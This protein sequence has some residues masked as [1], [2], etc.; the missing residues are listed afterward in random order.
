MEEEIDKPNKKKGKTKLKSKHNYGNYYFCLFI[1]I[2]IIEIILIINSSKKYE[3]EKKI[4]KYKHD[5]I[6]NKKN[7]I[8]QLIDEIEKNEKEIKYLESKKIPD[9]NNKLKL[10]QNEQFILLNNNKNLSEIFSKSYEEYETRKKIF[11]EEIIE[12]NNTLKK[13]YNELNNKVIIRTNLEEKLDII[14]SQLTGEIPNIKI[15]SSILENDENKIL[16]L[17]KWISSTT[18]GEIKKYKLIFSAIEHDFDS[19]SF[20]EI[21]GNEDI[22]N[23]LIIIKTENNDIIG[24]FTFASWR[25]NSLISYDDKAFVFNLNKEIKLRV[26]NP[27]YAINS[28]INDGPIFGIYDLIINLNKLKIQEKMESYGDKDLE[29]GNNV[30]KIDNYEVFTIIFK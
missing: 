24:G 20:H 25:A 10:I 17:T 6:V 18:G 26:S 28:K 30:I 23:T 22:D 11:E 19:F 16:L 7:N 3:Q 14:E 29:I 27:S 9:N 1:L 2:I 21:C 15:K 13:L 5:I 12:K 8:S 4:F